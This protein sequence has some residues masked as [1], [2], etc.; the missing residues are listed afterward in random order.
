MTDAFMHQHW[1]LVGPWRFISGSICPSNPFECHRRFTS[2]SKRAAGSQNF[3]VTR[4]RMPPCTC[5]DGPFRRHFART[6]ASEREKKISNRLSASSSF[7]NFRL[8]NLRSPTDLSDIPT[9]LTD[10][11]PIFDRWLR[12]PCPVQSKIRNETQLR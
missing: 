8:V 10:F 4:T 12:T 5:I 2:P 6:R 3:G 7:Q 11:W 9:D 1:T